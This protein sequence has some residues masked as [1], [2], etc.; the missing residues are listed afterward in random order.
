MSE[1]RGLLAR[2]RVFTDSPIAPLQSTWPVIIAIRTKD[3]HDAPKQLGVIVDSVCANGD[4]PESLPKAG[5][6][7]VCLIP[8]K[9]TSWYRGVQN[10]V[11]F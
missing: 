9:P 7:C 10:V 4:R 1:R 2:C 5:T 6:L 11:A 3:C 8:H